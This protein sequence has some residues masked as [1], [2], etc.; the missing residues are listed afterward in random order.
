MGYQ[1][2]TL[3]RA[4]ISLSNAKDLAKHPQKKC[5]SLANITARAEENTLAAFKPARHGVPEV[6]VPELTVTT[7]AFRTTFFR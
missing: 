7:D 4:S 6:S 3:C 5:Q 1:E 2:D